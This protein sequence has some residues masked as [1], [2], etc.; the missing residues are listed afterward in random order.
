MNI[1]NIKKNSFIKTEIEVSNKIK[2]VSLELEFHNERFVCIAIKANGM[3]A[4]VEKIE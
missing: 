1:L 3:S 2:I 4:V